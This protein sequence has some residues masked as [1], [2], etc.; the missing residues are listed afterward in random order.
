MTETS[1]RPLAGRVVAITGAGRGI[2]AAT[3]KLLA[4]LGASVTLGARSEAELSS[5]AEAVSA[6]GGQAAYRVTDVTKPGD[7]DGLVQLAIDRFGSVDALI[8]NAGMAV[9]SPL[10]DGDLADWNAMID[11]NLRG[12]LHGIAAALPHFVR[13]RS[14]HMVTVAS[15][16]SYEWMAGQGVYAAAKAGVRAVH[17]VLRREVAEFNVRSTLISPGFTRTEFVDS[18]TRDAAALEAIKTRRDAVAMP[19]KAVADAIAYALTQP[20]DINVGELIVRPT[21]A[22]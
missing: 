6:A 4:S 2:G 5:V 10:V 21:A 9:V 18:I 13:Q 16:A 17:E 20:D 12:V 14:G 7:L 15:I 22:P 11:I 1:I 19:P 3:A 8:N